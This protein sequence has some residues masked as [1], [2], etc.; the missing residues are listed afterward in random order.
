MDTGNGK[1]EGK[2]A[3]VSPSPTHLLSHARLQTRN[4]Q[5]LSSLV[6]RFGRL[7]VEISA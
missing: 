5:V 7:E 1:S 2:Y 6:C 3:F 4:D